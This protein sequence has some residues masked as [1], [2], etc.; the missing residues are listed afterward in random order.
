M[1]PIAQQAILVTGSTDG[2]G[3]QTVLALARQGA[4]V[5]LHGRDQQR[6]ETTR[7]AIQ[8]ETGNEHLESYLAD[9]ASLAEVRGLAETLQARHPRLDMLINNAGIGAGKRIEV[10]RELSRDGYEL[11]FAVNYLAP[12]LLTHLLLPCLRHT[13]PARI[14]N[15]SSV[16]QS[17]LDFSDV[18]LERRYDPMEAY[19]QSKLALVMF[20]FDLAEALKEEQITV[21]C[22]HPASL[23]NTKMV[24]ESFGYTMSTVEEG[25]GAVMYLATSPALD[26][27]SGTYFD[28]QREAQAHPQAY[29]LAAR[30]Q[31]RQ[32][33][34]HLTGLYGKPAV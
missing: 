22:L 7:K 14:I 33:S 12:F 27:V 5:L 16:G 9:F 11:R 8:D 31:L 34:E 24:D 29:N 10:R 3:K 30:S 18:M 28:Q 17:P 20:T 4:T 1:K 15:V 2:L 23:M 32:I 6:L 25:L 13:P 26:N 19:S 21:N